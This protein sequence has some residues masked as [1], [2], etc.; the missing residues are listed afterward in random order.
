V[1]H[2]REIWIRSAGERAY[3]GA[4]GE[5]DLGG[6]PMVIPFRRTASALGDAATSA[7]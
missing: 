3:E 4:A 5:R 2:L 6:R 7:T 1:E